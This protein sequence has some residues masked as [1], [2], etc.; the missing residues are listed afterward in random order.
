[1]SQENV[2]L[3][4]AVDAAAPDV[5]WAQ[6]FRDDETWA[7]WAEAIAP[8]FHAHVETVFPNVPGGRAYAGLDA[9][10]TGMLDWLAPWAT[11]RAEAEEV[12]DCGDRVLVLRSVFGRLE[13]SAEEVTLTGAAVFT[14]RDGKIAR[15]EGYADRDQALKAVGLE[16]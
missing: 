6:L 4:L 8:F 13:G 3:V 9:G 5:D 1:M 16:E 12:I 7:T 14:V 2:E 15:I 11:Y 10:R